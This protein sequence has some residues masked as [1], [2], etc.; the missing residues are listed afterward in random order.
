MNIEG[1]VALVTGARRGMGAEWVRQLLDRGASKV[2]AA[3]RDDRA[4]EIPGA[5]IVRLDVTDPESIR[6]AVQHTGDVSLL[7]NNAGISLWQSLVDGELE[8]I[9]RELET[10]LFG[11]LL[12]V[13]EFAPVLK[14]NGG[15]AIVNTLSNLSWFSY[16]GNTSYGVS[17]AA[18]WSLT[19]SIRLELAG[20]RTQVT[21]LYVGAVAT[22]MIAG[23]D[24]PTVAAADVVRAAIDGIEAGALEV[25]VDEP[26]REAKASLNLDPSV[27]YADLLA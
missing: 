3:V 14:A 2:Y 22:D 6:R 17:K 9:R 27:R 12:T 21:G 26:A 20:Q 4:D 1:S 23:Y 11:P 24:G 7:V 16:P 18:A 19:D 8:E 15:G 10:N 25:L 5:E 13:R